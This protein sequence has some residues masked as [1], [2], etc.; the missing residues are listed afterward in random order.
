MRLSAGM[1]KKLQHAKAVSHQ[2]SLVKLKRAHVTGSPDYS[3]HATSPSR[4][5]GQVHK[6]GRKTGLH[7]PK[8]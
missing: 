4:V 3:H 5:R 1:A 8:T 7:P 2:A 6:H